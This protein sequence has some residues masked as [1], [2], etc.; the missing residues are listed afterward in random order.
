[1]ILVK[2]SLFYKVL[3]M[4]VTASL[5]VVI[6]LCCRRFL[7]KAPKIFSYALWGVVLFRLLCPV[8][9]EL[10]FSFLSSSVTE[11][12]D[13]EQITTQHDNNTIATEDIEHSENTSP[14]IVLNGRTENVSLCSFASSLVQSFCVDCLH[15]SRKRYGN[16]L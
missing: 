3:H 15:F 4:S 12:V 1:M 16:E 13:L 11:N 7:K 9:L 5:V 8:S 2:V 10:P 6:V 14:A